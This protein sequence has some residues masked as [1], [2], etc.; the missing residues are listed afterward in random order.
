[1]LDWA[2][3][4]KIAVGAARGLA[5]LHEDCY[6][7]IIHR[8]IKSSNILLD[9]NFEARVS[10]FGLAKL[11]T[12]TNTHMTTRVVGTFGYLAPEYASSGKLTER[13]DVYSFG[14]LLL[15]LVTGRRP[16]DTS[17]PVGCESLVE[18]ARPLLNCAL[19]DGNF[20]DLADPELENNFDRDK[21]FCM[22]R[23]AAACTCYSAQRRPRMGQVVRVLEGDTGDYDLS[24]GVKPGH[25][26]Q[27]DCPEHSAFVRTF[28]MMVVGDQEYGSD[29]SCE[30]GLNPSVS[31]SEVQRNIVR[32]GRA[33]RYTRTESHSPFFGSCDDHKSTGALKTCAIIRPHSL[34]DD[35]W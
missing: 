33:A 22:L 25:S 35:N 14:V 8:D 19:Q 31:S 29:Y 10:D 9:N 6:P 4:L 30:Y 20:E 11:A 13:S 12:D 15:E 18:W 21:M 27:Y 7:Q 3:R 17:Q 5:Y 1:M 2:T 16:V 32:E 24:N 28:R 26:A 34:M 23:V